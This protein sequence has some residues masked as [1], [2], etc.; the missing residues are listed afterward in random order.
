MGGVKSVIPLCADILTVFFM[1][2]FQMLNKEHEKA[3]DSKPVAVPAA[4]GS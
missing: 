4:A 2:I 3:E 1:L